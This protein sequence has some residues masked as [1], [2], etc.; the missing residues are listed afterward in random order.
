[1]RNA[2]AAGLPHPPKSPRVGGFNQFLRVRNLIHTAKYPPFAL[3]SSKLLRWDF[4][5]VCRCKVNPTSLYSPPMSCWRFQEL[6]ATHGLRKTSLKSRDRLINGPASDEG[7]CDLCGSRSFSLLHTWEVG[8]T[9]NP[10]TVPLTIGKCE[11]GLVFLRPVPTKDQL[12]DE[13]EWWS[14]KR[15][16][17]R[18]N[19]WFKRIRTRIIRRTLGS[20]AYRLVRDTHKIVPSGRYL[21]V[22]CGTGTLL[23]LASHFY[24]CVGIEPSP[25]AAAEAREKGF[26]VIESS[27]EEAPI[28][29]Q[30]F[31]VVLMGSVIEHV[32]SPMAFLKK[33]NYI[34]KPGGVVVMKTPKF[35]GPA[36]RRHKSGWNGFRHGYHTFLY[37]GETLGR[38]LQQTGFEVLTRPKRDRFLDDISIL[39]GRKVVEVSGH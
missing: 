22:G 4:I 13:G 28:E 24:Q 35:G 39:W 25:I 5:G 20:T 30:S 26:D 17:P 9:W 36:Y 19:M 15:K 37:T 11:C 32:Q 12:P 18:R 33:V 31:D 8:D 14:T 27:F 2:R 38:Y 3:R 10:A 23:T 7:G 16:R 1:M 6:E 29:P 34:L 21:D